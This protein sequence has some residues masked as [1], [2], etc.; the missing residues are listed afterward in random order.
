[1]QLE[2]SLSSNKHPAQPKIDKLKKNKQVPV[3]SSG[4]SFW[5]ET[6][7]LW[8]E[9]GSGVGISVQCLEMEEFRNPEEKKRRGRDYH[10]MPLRM[11]APA[12]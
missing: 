1:M 4:P 3:L 5:L 2:K 7:S 8:L 9:K 11:V 10:V 12:L 6:G